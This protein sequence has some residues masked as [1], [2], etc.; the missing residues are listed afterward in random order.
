MALVQSPYRSNSEDD[1]F[2][3]MALAL[4][5]TASLQQEVP[6]GAVVVDTTTRDVIGQ[7]ANS[8]I[9]VHDCTAH[10]EVIALRQACAHVK[11]YRLGSSCTLYVTLMPCLMCLGAILNARVGRLVVGC[12]DS[13]F[14]L[15]VDALRSFFNENPV[16]W[17]SCQIET[18][19]LHNQAKQLLQNFFESR[20]KKPTDT[21]PKL[22]ALSDLPNLNQAVVAWLKQTGYVK[23]IDLMT[24]NVETVIEKIK[25]QA[26]NDCSLGENEVAMLHS[27]CHYLEGY[28]QQSWRKFL[29]H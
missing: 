18:G 3:S 23:G 7:G 27:L 2:M 21:L 1:F 10:A 13:R 9:S 24:P 29:N 14:S 17:G 15:S 11:N 8:P 28:G 26:Q 22:K 16:A 19:C 20:R 4:A 5:K 12:E 25:H 6:I